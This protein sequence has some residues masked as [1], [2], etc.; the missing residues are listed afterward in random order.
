MKIISGLLLFHPVIIFSKVPNHTFIGGY[1]MIVKNLLVVGVVAGFASAAAAQDSK[2]SWTVGG[3]VRV[4]A[5]QTSTE[6]DGEDGKST[7]KASTV[8]LNRAQFTLNGSRDGHGLALTYYADS[9]ELYTAVISHKFSDMIT[10]HFGRMR[11]LAQSVEN[12]Y[13]EIDSYIKSMAKDHAPEN[14][15]GVRLDFGF[16]GDHAVSIQAVEGMSKDKAGNEFE[17]NGGLTTAL[18]YRGNLNN[19]MVKP[20]V[21]YTQVR[22]TARKSGAVDRSNGYMNQLGLGAQMSFSG[23]AVDLEYDS[24]TMLKDKAVTGAKD[25]TLTSL[26]AQVKYPV[27]ATTPFLKLASETMKFGA[28]KG[29][30][31]WTGMKLALGVEHALDASCRLHAV[32]TSD[33]TT[34]EAGEGNKDGKD[35][36]TGFNFGVTASM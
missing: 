21:T 14:S 34:T 28:E 2:G 26:V 25:V 9:N 17:K 12:S 13:D 16:A 32:Y 5:V 24:G 27:G 3:R 31:D 35:T 29:V 8:G 19:G 10:A 20:I 22:T 11:V 15:E 30:N 36:T 6:E 1:F 33:A 23:A 4:D 18:Q 7:S